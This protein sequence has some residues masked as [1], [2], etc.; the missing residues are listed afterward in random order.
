MRRHGIW[1]AAIAAAASSLAALAPAG[2]AADYAEACR[3]HHG[4]LVC[5]RPSRPPG[6]T[7][8]HAYDRWQDGSI[9]YGHGSSVDRYQFPQY[10]GGHSAWYGF[11]R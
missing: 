3:M 1:I 7:W 8:G 10:L 2:H 5:T 9:A 4:R 6:A 11:G